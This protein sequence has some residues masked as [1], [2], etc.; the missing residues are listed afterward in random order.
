MSVAVSWLFGAVV[1]CGAAGSRSR[2]VRE[3][4]DGFFLNVQLLRQAFISGPQGPHLGRFG[5]VRGQGLL[6]RFLPGMEPL[7]IDIQGAGGGQ[8]GA[9]F[10]GQAQGFG[11]EGRIITRPF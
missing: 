10:A 9:A 11:A 8:R 1:R 2:G 4:D 5:R 6:G 7:G 3:E